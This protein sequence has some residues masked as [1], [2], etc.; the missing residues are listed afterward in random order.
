[1]LPGQMLRFE[2]LKMKQLEN[3]VSKSF[4][5]LSVLIAV[6]TLLV[7]DAALAQPGGG[8]GRGGQ[9]GGF[10]GF[11]GGDNTLGLLS[12]QKVQEEL[13]LVDDQIQELQ[14]IRDSSMQVMRDMFQGMQDV[15]PQDRQARMEEMRTKIADKMK[16]FEDEAN[17][18]LLPHQKERLKQIGFQA[19]GRGRGG[20]NAGGALS[21]EK[22]LDELGVSDDQRKEIEEATQKAREELQKKYQDLVRAA[23]NDILKV[24][25]KEQRARYKELIGE[26]FDVQS[27]GGGFGPGGPG[28]QGGRGG[29]GG[30][31][32]QGG[33]GGRGGRGGQGGQSDF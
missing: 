11:G 28:A 4:S 7:A 22:L 12:N 23:E 1:M 33:R 2:K 16:S 9:R 17:A 13:E 8:G 32:A 6:G 29:Q 3:P 21:N 26:P 14:A 10:G 5:F 27:M 19:S 25:T 24:L 20:A 15:A 18:V 31:G 30:P